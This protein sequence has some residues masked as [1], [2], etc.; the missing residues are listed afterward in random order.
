MKVCRPTAEETDFINNTQQPVQTQSWVLQSI[1][2]SLRV[3]HHQLHCRE[4]GVR[5]DQLSIAYAKHGK[6][7]PQFSLNG[8]KELNKERSTGS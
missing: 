1:H 6:D 5:C 3:S 2:P 8:S 4:I 7:L